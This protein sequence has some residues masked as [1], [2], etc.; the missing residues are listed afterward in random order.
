MSW[1]RSAMLG[2]GGLALVF[3]SA[4]PGQVPVDPKPSTAETSV[5]ELRDLQQTVTATTAKVLPA[6]VGIR[7]GFGQGSGVIVSP[8]GFVLTASH[9]VAGADRDRRLTVILRDGTE[10][11]A[12][13]ID[14]QPI[15]GN[16]S[17]LVK[18]TARQ[19]VGG[20]PYAPVGRSNEVDTGDW[21]IAAGH[22]GGYRADRPPVIRLGRVLFNGDFVVISDNTLVGGDSGGPLFDLEGSVIG[23]HSRIG[24]AAS[25]N[26][27]VPIDVFVSQWLGESFTEPVQPIIGVS[28]N[29]ANGAAL[30]QEVARRSP[31][32]RAGIRPND[33]IVRFN[34]TPTATFDDLM[35]AVRRTRPGDV[36]DVEVQRPGLSQVLVFKLTV[37]SREEVRRGW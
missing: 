31:A 17:A 10:L 23:I 36:V 2:L 14:R 4:A 35:V 25:D 1:R 9:V 34:G 32:D 3:L 24:E 27:H 11:P 7:A 20:F 30:V 5:D 13:L 22:P 28:T 19:P 8:D 21:C 15:R 6:V 16:D 12:R 29:A 26:K 18:I 33:T 37:G